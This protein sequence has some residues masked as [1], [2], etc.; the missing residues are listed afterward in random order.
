MHSS[1]FRVFLPHFRVFRGAPGLCEGF[2]TRACFA[3]SL[4]VLILT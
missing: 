3:R 2:E 1:S 4:H